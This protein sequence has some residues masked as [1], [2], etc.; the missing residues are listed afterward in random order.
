MNLMGK[1]P[2]GQ[3]QGKPKNG[4]AAGIEHMRRVKLLPCVCCGAPP[5]SDAHHCKSDFMLRDDFK[6]IPLCKLHHQGA[7]GY[8]TQKGAWEA[9]HGKDHAFLPMVAKALRQKKTG[10]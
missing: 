9:R 6:T 10:R 2:L 5:P 1:G 8:H 3:K 7:E 4:T